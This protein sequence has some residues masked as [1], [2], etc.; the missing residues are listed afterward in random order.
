MSKTYWTGTLVD[1]CQLCHLPFKGVMYDAALGYAGAP[2]ANVCDSCF[3]SLGCKLGLGYG[4]KYQQQ[5]DKRWLKVK[6]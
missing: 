5:K 4:Q 6:G 3:N 2:W 1:E